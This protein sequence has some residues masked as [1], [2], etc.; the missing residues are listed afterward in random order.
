MDL[1]PAVLF[2]ADVIQQLAITEANSQQKEQQVGGHFLE[3]MSRGSM[4]MKDFSFR[5]DK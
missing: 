2:P 5:T 1:Y 4:T 3:T